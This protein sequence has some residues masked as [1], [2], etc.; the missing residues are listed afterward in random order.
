MSMLERLYKDAILEHYKRPHNRGEIADARHRHEGLNPSCGDELELFLRVE[1]GVVQ[2]ARFVGTG[3]AISQAS[4]SMMTDRIQG[5]TVEKALEIAAAFKAMIR[6][7]PPADLLG[8][9]AVLQGV[10]QL[11]ARVKC[12]DLAWI[13]LEHA[14]A[15]GAQEGSQAGHRAERSDRPVD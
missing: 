14:L 13:T 15:A 2:A 9:P 5:E 10:S 7:E 8:E 4:A 3:C 6:G 12:A 1:D 11:P